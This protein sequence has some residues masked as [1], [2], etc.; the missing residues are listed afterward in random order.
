LN[1]R[2]S[3]DVVPPKFLAELFYDG[4][5]HEL[6]PLHAALCALREA[7]TSATVPDLHLICNRREATSGIGHE[8]Q[9]EVTIV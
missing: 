1:S 5:L 2:R 3:N 4:V 7:R 9:H 8:P 6:P